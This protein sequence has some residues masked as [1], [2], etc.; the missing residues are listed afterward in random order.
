[1]RSAN[2]RRNNQTLVADARGSQPDTLGTNRVYVMDSGAFPA[3]QAEPC[4]QLRDDATEQYPAEY[5]ALN[6]S[7]AASGRVV[8]T[9]CPPNYVC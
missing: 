2:A 3:R 6:A 4:M 9:G 1:M 7:L 8:E 5:H